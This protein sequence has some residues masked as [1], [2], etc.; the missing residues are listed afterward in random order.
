VR[1]AATN[2]DIERHGRR[3]VPVD[4]T[5]Q[6]RH[7]PSPLRDDVD[8]IAPRP[9]SSC[10]PSHKREKP[11]RTLS[12]RA[13]DPAGY[14]WRQRSRVETRHQGALPCA[15]HQTRAFPRVWCEGGSRATACSPSTGGE[16]SHP[17]GFSET[18]GS[19]LKAAR[20]RVPESPTVSWALRGTGW[21][22]RSPPSQIRPRSPRRSESSPTAG[23]PPVFTT[24]RNRSRRSSGPEPGRRDGHSLAVPST[25]VFST[26]D[27]RFHPSAGASVSPATERGIQRK[28]LNCRRLLAFRGISSSRPRISPDALTTRKPPI[29]SFE[30]SLDPEVIPFD[31]ST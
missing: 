6:R 9:G 21:R 19:K 3:L 27:R 24:A 23:R 4:P 25:S 26:I 8:D 18:A 10:P 28:S 13:G 29:A 5:A 31:Y 12:S 14:S 11:V 30:I 16:A 2:V 7:P 15:N 20:L 22:S 17:A 1:V